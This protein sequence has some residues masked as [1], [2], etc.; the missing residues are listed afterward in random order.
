[1]PK[2][3]PEGTPQAIVDGYNYYFVRAG[4]EQYPTYQPF[5][6][7]TNLLYEPSLTFM[8]QARYFRTPFLVVAGE[9]A[10]TRDM[11]REVYELAAGKKE[12]FEV[13]GAS[14]TDLYDGDVYVDQAVDRIDA[15]F[16]Q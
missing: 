13:K 1:M 12:W 7:T 5:Y 15:F 11:D 10:M 4:K 16:R 6:P 8:H 14:Q 9:K 2:P 3:P